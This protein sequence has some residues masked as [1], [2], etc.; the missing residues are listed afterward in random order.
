MDHDLF[1][2]VPQPERAPAPEA[3]KPLT[4]DDIRAM[5][6]ALIEAVSGVDEIPFTPAEFEKHI[7]MFPIMAQWLPDDEGQQLCF[8]FDQ[9]VERLKKAA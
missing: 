1:G 9:Q 6:R 4:A 3:R 2:D 5:M 8:E 7:A